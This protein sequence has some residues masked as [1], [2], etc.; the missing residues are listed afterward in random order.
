[1]TASQTRLKKCITAT[2]SRLKK[3]EGDWY[4]RRK[5]TNQSNISLMVT[6]TLTEFLWAKG[7]GEN[8]INELRRCFDSRCP[9]SEAMHKAML[10]YFRE[11]IACSH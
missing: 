8:V 3:C 9:V 11:Y 5:I 6:S 2:K 7:I 1:M 10:R 4:V